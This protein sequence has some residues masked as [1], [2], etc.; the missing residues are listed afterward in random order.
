MRRRGLVL[1]LCGALCSCDPEPVSVDFTLQ[2]D[3]DT[4]GSCS[5]SQ[6]TL[7][8]ADGFAAIYAEGLGIDKGR[9]LCVAMNEGALLS[10]IGTQIRA[11]LLTGGAPTLPRGTYA[12]G[13]SY[14]PPSVVDVIDVCFERLPS[15]AV[16]R[17]ETIATLDG[18]SPVLIPITLE[19]HG[20]ACP[21]TA[22]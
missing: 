16:I 8:G 13:V 22:D 14:F 20:L 19:C 1:V 17:G 4:C 7:P 5:A 12:F 11:D 9:G 2:L 21:A 10:Q 15:E 18:E 6:I 3:P